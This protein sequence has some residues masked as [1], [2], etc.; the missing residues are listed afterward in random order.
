MTKADA[1]KLVAIVC[2]AYP[3][4]EKFRSAEAVQD[5]V[6][7]WALMFESDD[8][9]LVGLAVKKHIATN[10]WPPSVAEIREIM[11]EMTAPD[12][13]PPDQAW[14]SV[15]E[16]FDVIGMHAER[17]EY[18]RRLPALVA[19]AVDAV[20]WAHLKSL[21]RDALIGEKAGMDRVA[22]IAQYTPMYE[23]EKLRAMTPAGVTEQI[24]NTRA[25]RLESMKRTPEG[26]HK[27]LAPAEVEQLIEKGIA[28]VLGERLNT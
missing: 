28:L 15:S 12:L 25:L 20:G 8:G 23:R 24:D 7:L 13:I 9:A 19:G 11:L 17:S 22:F 5:T 14:Q 6:N 26:P 1:A 10:K 21:H 16:L 27:A 2:T 18:R 3:N 4:F